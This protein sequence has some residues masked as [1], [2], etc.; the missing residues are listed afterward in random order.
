ME[1]LL[2]GCKWS[3]ASKTGLR[4]ANVPVSTLLAFVLNFATN[5]VQMA[6]GA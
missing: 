1:R 3:K 4:T 5:Q 2:G 6:R